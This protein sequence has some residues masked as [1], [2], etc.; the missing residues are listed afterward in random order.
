MVVARSRK[1]ERGAHRSR[2]AAVPQE[3]SYVTLVALP[4]EDNS[5]IEDYYLFPALRRAFSIDVSRNDRWFKFGVHLTKSECFCDV[6][7]SLQN[8]KMLSTS[9]EQADFEGA[10]IGAASKNMLD[11]VAMSER[12]PL[13]GWREIAKHLSKTLSQAYYLSERGLTRFRQGG[14]VCAWPKEVEMWVKAHPVRLLRPAV[15]PIPEPL[16]RR[17]LHC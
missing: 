1:T 13:V 2:I 7:I 6:V 11:L 3:R 14:S 9:H 10:R 16:R 5:G 8:A 4:T 12:K 17:R 15:R